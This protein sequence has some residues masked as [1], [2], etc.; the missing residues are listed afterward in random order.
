[1]K[2]FKSLAYG[3]IAAIIASSAAIA[4]PNSNNVF[5]GPPQ[6]YTPILAGQTDNPTAT[7]T[8]QLGYFYSLGNMTFVSFD[9]VTSGTTT[10]TTTTDNFQVSLPLPSVTQAGHFDTLVCDTEN[11]TPIQY[12]SVGVIGSAAST[13][14]IQGWTGTAPALNL[15]Q[16]TWAT[17]SPGI[18]ALSH[19]LTAKCSGWYQTSA[20]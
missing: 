13:V 6:V 5:N 2:L 18:G 1:M 15:S 8:T 3:F 7:Y 9:L 19:V 17:A 4:V 12:G 20:Q 14:L 10:K 16:M 11:A